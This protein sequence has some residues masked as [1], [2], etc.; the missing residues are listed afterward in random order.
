[1]KKSDINQPPC[2][3]DKYIDLVD[4]VEL[5]EAFGI[6]LT[7]L[8]QLDLAKLEQVGDAVYADGKWT[9]RSSFQHL[10]DAER[11]LSYRALRIGRN[12]ETE[13]P[14]FDEALFAAN[15]DA[16]NR[17]LAQIVDELKVVRNATRLLY[18]TF[19]A[20]AMQRHATISGN[21][22]SVLAYGFAILGHQ[23]HHENIIEAKYLPLA[24]R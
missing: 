24:T 14:G 12:D 16:R 15:V 10:I 19:D 6:S 11:V 7:Q 1:M 21:R 8:D 9:I 4:D 22:M 18:E 17:S 23:V 2:Y 20:E 13:L 5:S 3:F